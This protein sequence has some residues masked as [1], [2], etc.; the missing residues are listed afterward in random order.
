MT[1]PPTSRRRSR[2]RS[3][4]DA[5]ASAA[6]DETR[7]AAQ[8][9]LDEYNLG[10][11][12]TQERAQ[13]D[14]DYAAEVRRIQSD[15]ARAEAEMN[16]KLA[17]LSDAFQNGTGTMDD[18]RDVAAEYGI[19]IDTTTIPDFATLSAASGALIDAFGALA[20]YIAK[21]TGTAPAKIPSR[22]SAAGDLASILNHRVLGRNVPLLDVGGEVLQT[23]LAIVHRGET[24]S[25]VGSHR[26]PGGIVLEAG[27]V[28]VN[29]NYIHER[30]L[31]TTIVRSLE[32]YV[33]QGGRP[34]A[35]IAP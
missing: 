17:R 13:A 12:A 30:D 14:K 4:T 9:A 22:P 6:D 31:Q 8:R 15:R 10:L 11:R 2:T 23:G 24:F 32:E 21:I 1:P 27:A 3:L 29:G 25:G 28:Q 35:G 26:M 18:L 16:A 20:D 19:Q 5:V 7:K 34:I 33:R